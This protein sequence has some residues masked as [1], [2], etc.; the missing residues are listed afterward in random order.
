MQIKTD[1]SIENRV[2]YG[3][4]LP[5]TY[6][7]EQWA[8]GHKDYF[9]KFEGFH[10][11][12]VRLT[13][14]VSSIQ[15]PELL[16]QLSAGQPVTAISEELKLRLSDQ[17][18]KRFGTTALDAA[19]LVYRPVAYLLNKDAYERGSPSSPHG[20]S[21]A[22][23][24]SITQTTKQA[25]FRIGQD[26]DSALTT[27]AVKQLDTDT[28]LD[29][30]GV[31]ITRLGD[32]ELL[33]FPALDEEERQLLDVS[34]IDVP[35]TLVV[36]FTPSQVP[37]FKG[38]Q[39]KLSITN[40][41]QLIYASL[42]SAQQDAEGAFEG[43]FELS[44]QI[45][46]R[47]DST[48]L[49]IFGFNVENPRESLL[50]CRW[51]V[52]YVREIH[53]QS[54]ALGHS[55]NAVKFDWL[56]RAVRPSAADRVKAALTIN[57]GS[58]GFANRIGERKA[59]PW[60]PVNRDLASLFTRLRPPR[61]EGQF[62]LRRNQGDGDGRLQFV[63]WFKTLLQKYRQHQVVIFDPYFEAAGLGLITISAA[64]D[65]DYIVFTSLPK[66]SKDKEE[67]CKE[68]GDRALG[69]INNLM[70]GCEQSR[71]LLRSI[72]L[73]IF[74]LKE[75]RLHDRYIL[76]LGQ[77][78]LP[79]A[80][81][82]LSNSLQKATENHPLLV[83]PIPAD[84]LL[85]VEQYKSG[86][87]Q[88]AQATQ[89]DSEAD[90]PSIGLLFDSALPLTAMRRYEPLRFLEKRQAGDVLGAWSGEPSLRGLSGDLLKERMDALGLLKEN[91]L[92]L[93]QADGLRNCLRQDASTLADFS[94]NWE[95]IGEVLA[96]SHA[97]DPRFREL[98]SE[99]EF[100]N[101]LA[102]FLEASFNRTHDEGE[103]ELAVTRA[104]FFREPI[105]SLLYS[106]YR[107][108]SLIHA[109]KFVAL[110]WAEF[111][112]IKFLW[113]FAPDALLAMFETQ[114]VAVPVEADAADVVRLS[115]LSQIASEVSLSIQFDTSS[116]QLNH[117]IRSSSG[118][119]QWMGLN[120]IERQLEE[121]NGTATVVRSVAPL[122]DFEKVRALGWMVNHAAGDPVRAEIYKALI[123]ALHEALPAE[124]LA[125]DLSRLVDSMRG[126]MKRLAWAEPWLFRDVLLP[127]LESERAKND[128]ACEIWIQ[129]L[130][131]LLEPD[132]R[133]GP[134]LFVAAREGQTTN[135]AAFLFAYSS[136][137]RQQES[138]SL[139]RA[140]LA[141][142][143]RILHQPLAST[144]N[145]ARW[146]DALTV[147]M[148]VLSFA[149]WGQYYLQGRGLVDQ[150]LEK[151]SVDA[152]QLAMVRP[153]DEWRSTSTGKQGELAMFLDQIDQLL[154]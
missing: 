23:S 94:A 63:E 46:S 81:F 116:V 4:L 133:H 98:A 50:C 31:D 153:I 32:L 49:E 90:G 91:S 139:M 99:H 130:D 8:A 79:V 101:F 128:D 69:R 148:W 151:L 56:E 48:E 52:S 149:R 138:L 105:E 85:K 144:S 121:P 64:P 136:P 134:R 58:L 59:D 150:Q 68:S 12:V 132:P 14:Y 55:R 60:V 125:A 9:E 44:E 20:G 6:A 124:M 66:V 126:H 86:L 34:W 5:Y 119:L 26:Y 92:A 53:I 51:R 80:G 103:K 110:T 61:S 152:R 129:E 27:L 137:A 40:G 71:P 143:K 54:H 83:T 21:G 107:P 22:F 135:V 96:H 78:G 29:F 15:C 108:H 72:K 13:L 16:R 118:L 10:A 45:R 19:G 18:K 140:H 43:R 33:V 127:L 113:W 37:N 120:A 36:R 123:I 75:G 17:L 24:A 131:A 147:S 77:E 11:Q 57:R 76:V 41:D 87:M 93:P 67:T 100:L 1:Q 114:V 42:T 28:G 73:R 47:T 70:A 145:W 30:G 82:N 146:D 154:A 141:R 104:W 109:T 25:L 7:D 95:V 74:G 35:P 111:Y 88:E 3:R 2:I 65:A 106:S 97:E 39:F 142:Q 102:R 38:F 62:F 122:P 84:V 117:L 89:L 115:L 112:T